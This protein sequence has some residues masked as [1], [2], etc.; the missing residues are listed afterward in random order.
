[1]FTKIRVAVTRQCEMNCIYC[2]RGPAV[3]MENYDG[4][5]LYCLT[6]DEL[7]GVLS[8]MVGKGLWE[9]H[10]TGGEPL[11]RKRLADLIRM[12]ANLGAHVE[13]N[14]NGLGLTTSGTREL[15]AAGLDFLKV[16]LDVPN[17][18]A[19]LAFTGIDAFDR[20]VDGIKAALPILPVRLNC[21]V[22]RCNIGSLIPLIRMAD[23]LGV[24]KV[25]LLDLT[26]YPCAGGREF[27]ER[28]FV[29]LTK[30]VV[31]PLEDEFGSSFKLM[32]VYGCRFY[33]ME[34]RPGGTVIVLKEA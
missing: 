9:V 26:F 12:I 6:D 15:K 3:K 1:M 21:V 5:E 30:E 34:S 2:P 24:Q 28:E 32:P 16:S 11:R 31:G 33:E 4:E 25:H 29:Y 13:L 10:L 8:V 27:W 7:V 18:G 19:F 23:E 14:T 17:R 20:V 22:M